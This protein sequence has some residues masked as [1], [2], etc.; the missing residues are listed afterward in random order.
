[1]LGAGDVVVVLGI[2]DILLDLGDPAAICVAR[3]LVNERNR[4][5]DL[6]A[7]ATPNEDNESTFGGY[8]RGGDA[9][10]NTSTCPG[11]NQSGTFMSSWKRAILGVRPLSTPRPAQTTESSTG[12]RTFI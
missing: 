11:S 9:L 12:A 7:A 10:S 3:L 2:G 1:V 6:L 5:G 4:S 8:P